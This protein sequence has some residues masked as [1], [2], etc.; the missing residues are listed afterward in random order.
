MTLNRFKKLILWLAIACY[1]VQAVL[2]GTG[3]AICLASHHAAEPL[4][5]ACNSAC[6]HHSTCDGSGGV[7]LVPQHDE[8]DSCPCTD[9][10]IKD[11]E[12]GRIDD[13]VKLLAAQ[14]KALV[15]VAIDAVR[16][17]GI[18]LL[19][20]MLTFQEARPVANQ[21]APGVVRTVVILI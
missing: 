21:I 19:S 15:P 5:I 16:P 4:E 1:S 3:L 2:G 20:S 10:S 8:H 11:S 18:P 17:D 14:V 6:S 13:Q 9:I 7:Q 12:P